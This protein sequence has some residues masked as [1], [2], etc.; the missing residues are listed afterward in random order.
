[1]L[2]LKDLQPIT[3]DPCVRTPV[4][5]PHDS[6]PMLI[7]PKHKVVWVGMIVGSVNV[8]NQPTLNVKQ[9][10]YF[11]NTLYVLIALIQSFLQICLFYDQCV[12]T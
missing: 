7:L 8:W 4:S 2:Y 12:I 5:V 10:L 1:M 9:E 3:F 6:L 11:V